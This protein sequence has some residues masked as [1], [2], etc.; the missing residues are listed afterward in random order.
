M[1]DKT[2]KKPKTPKAPKK[3]TPEA[4]AP[5]TKKGGGKAG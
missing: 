3:P 1:S 2:P 5:A 4:T